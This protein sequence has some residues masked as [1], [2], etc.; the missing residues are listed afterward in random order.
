MQDTK[1]ALVS[2]LELNGLPVVTVEILDRL[3]DDLDQESIAKNTRTSYLSDWESWLHF[4]ERHRIKPIPAGPA[5]V[6]RYL[7][8]LGAVG[9]RK[10]AKLRPRSAQRHL[11]AIAAAHRA[12]GLEFDTRHPILKRTMAGILRRYGTRQQGARALRAADIEVMC[13]SFSLDLRSVRN[14]AIILLGFAGGFR[15]SEIVALNV[16]D[17]VFEEGLLRVTIRRSKTDQIGQGRTIVIMPGENPPTCAVAAARAWLRAADLEEEGDTPAFRP[18][19]V[20]GVE[21]T[22]LSDKT[23]DRIV[24]SAARAAGLKESYSAHSLRA[25]HVTEALARGADRATIKRQTGHS[26]DAMLDRYAR[27]TNLAANNSSSRIGL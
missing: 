25:G 5:D 24:K 12:A 18:V 22:R 8:Q 13:K 2:S 1:G 26:S 15:R 14:K 4:C 20:C 19:S 6:R 11:A 17:L 27:E 9:G 10:G 7:T 16:S 21:F 3:A 23:V